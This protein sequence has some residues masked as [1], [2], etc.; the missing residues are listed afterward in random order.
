M[1]SSVL[2]PHWHLSFALGKSEEVAPLRLQPRHPEG[3]A[4]LSVTRLG[5]TTRHHLVPSILIC[6]FIVPHRLESKLLKNRD[7]I[8]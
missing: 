6:M 2:P 5:H 3:T 8:V 1:G 7:F 4:L